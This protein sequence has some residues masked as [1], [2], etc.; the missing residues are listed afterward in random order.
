MDINYFPAQ[1]LFPSFLVTQPPI[2]FG[3][4]TP[5]IQA[6]FFGWDW[7]HPGSGGGHVIQT[8]ANKQNPCPSYRDGLRDVA[9]GVM[10]DRSRTSMDNWAGRCGEI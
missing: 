3:S 9:E 1:Y 7:L 8:W 6:V 2:S 10:M 5:Y 4:H